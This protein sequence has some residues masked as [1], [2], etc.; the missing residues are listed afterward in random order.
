MAKLAAG[1]VFTVKAVL[2][3]LVKP[4]ALAVSCLSAPVASI[5]RLL[6]V[7]APLPAAVPMS[8]D[9]VPCNGPV[10]PVRLRFKF[11][12]A[13]RLAAE[14]LPNWSSAQTTG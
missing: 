13:G 2:T 14:T 11:R 5:R 12:L 7:T 4:D 9:A 6:N 3:A 1:P 10:P 8:K